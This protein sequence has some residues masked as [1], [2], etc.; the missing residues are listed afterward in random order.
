MVQ[1]FK[2]GEVSVFNDNIIK[3]LFADNNFLY[4]FVQ[5]KKINRCAFSIIDLVG[6]IKTNE[7]AKYDLYTLELNEHNYL[8]YDKFNH[9]FVYFSAFG[10][11][12]ITPPLHKNNF[13]FFG[14]AERDIYISFK[15]IKD[16]FMALDKFNSI[17]TWSGV[18]GKK[19]DFKVCRDENFDGFEIFNPE[20]YSK[21]YYKK[22]L[23]IR[24]KEE[25]DFD[26]SEFFEKNGF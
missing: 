8:D 12:Y 1:E 5:N 9:R 23:M 22:V 6:T 17:T 19:L 3:V 2:N 10:Q 20:I 14:M 26:E 25:Q 21:E 4:C 7:L 15:Q 13:T 24:K 11:I 18:T 16:R